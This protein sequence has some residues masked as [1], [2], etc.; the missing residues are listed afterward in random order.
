MSEFKPPAHLTAEMRAWVAATAAEYDLEAHHIRLLIL[1]AETYD[2]AERARK[3]LVKEGEYV[4]DRFGQLRQHPAVPVLRDARAAF[5]RLVREIGLD[6]SDAS[7]R[8]P[9][10]AGRH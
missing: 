10:I 6:D 2:Q 1:A 7:T 5:A 3:R 9:R 8:P 4:E